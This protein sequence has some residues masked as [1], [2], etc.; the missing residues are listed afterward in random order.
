MAHETRFGHTVGVH[1]G[2]RAAGPADLA[3]VIERWGGTMAAHGQLFDLAALEMVVLDAGDGIAGALSWAV[4]GDV[5]EIVSCDA[6][7]AGRGVGR[8]LVEAAV[9]I[10]AVRRL[11]RLA[12]TT[13][14]DNLPA[15]GFWQAMGFR[16]V[17]LRPGAVRDARRLKPA[18]PERGYRGLPIRDELDLERALEDDNRPA[19]PYTDEPRR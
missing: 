3:W 19:S 4:E 8:A 2:I 10:A 6:D 15:L 14:N 11:T 18:I 12:A 17:A 5:F 13:T 9:G 1:P 16:L 7:P